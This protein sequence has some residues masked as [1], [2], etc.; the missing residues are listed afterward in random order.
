MNDQTHV[1]TLIL[2]AG[3]SGLLAAYKLHQAGRRFLL[4]EARDRVGGRIY[5]K[6][7]ARDTLVEMGATWLGE[8]HTELLELLKEL[9]IS[10]Y[11]Q[12][13]EGTAFFEAFSTAPAQAVELPP[14]SPSFRIEGG[15]NALVQGLYE[16]LPDESIKLGMPVTNMNF[17]EDRVKVTSN[18]IVW[19]G[20]N[21]ISCMPPRVLLQHVDF[22]PS[23]NTAMVALA[24]STQTWM[25]ES[26]KV[27][28]VYARP[29][30]R[31]R[32]FSGTIFSN[33]GPI[34]EFYDHSDKDERAFAL[35]GFIHGGF[36]A[37]PTDKRQ[38]LVLAQLRQIFGL[39]A[40]DYLTI[41]EK[42]WS[43]EQFSSVVQTTPLF[44]HQNNGHALY[45]ESLYDGRLVIAG[46]ETSTSFGGY[47]E[48]A[49]RSGRRAV[50]KLL[51]V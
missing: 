4:L 6:A 39:D 3:L 51:H 35:C 24:K 28:V 1:D 27:A 49:V 18:S 32:G 7:S 31:M 23:L 10:I 50:E 43:T 13:I 16:Q 46:S 22:Q 8:Q 36:R 37:L 30:W 42:D 11:P 25:G 33:V 2:G 40:D 12:F 9:S 15:S 44:P 14:Q 5:S 38:A 41:E 26:I 45:Q 34:Q 20:D 19:E 47:M 29:F 17:E 21:V 48:G